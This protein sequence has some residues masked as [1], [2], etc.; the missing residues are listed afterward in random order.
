MR[1]DIAA[2]LPRA[3]DNDIVNALINRH[4]ERHA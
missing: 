3:N 4:D 2:S 1:D